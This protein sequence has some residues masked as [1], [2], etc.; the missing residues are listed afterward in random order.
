MI[1]ANTAA[2]RRHC[3]YAVTALL[4]MMTLKSENR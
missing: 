1:E 4:G 3:E 2:L